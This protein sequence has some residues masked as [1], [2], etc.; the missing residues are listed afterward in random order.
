M[1]KNTKYA[2]EMRAALAVVA[3]I[4]AIVHPAHAAQ[5]EL[6]TCDYT[7]WVSSAV[8]N[9]PSVPQAMRTL[10]LMVETDAV[11]VQFPGMHARRYPKRFL[12]RGFAFGEAN[13]FSVK[14]KM[15]LLGNEYDYRK[16][17]CTEAE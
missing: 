13:M 14:D 15:L 8:P 3:A 9:P 11:V 7:G 16:F 12:V 4:M 6:Y 10:D 17:K 2:L 5:L 1:T